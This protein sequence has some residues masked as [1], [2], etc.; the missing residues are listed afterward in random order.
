M[1][2]YQMLY[3]IIQTFRGLCEKTR[4]NKAMKNQSVIVSLCIIDIKSTK[5]NS[6]SF[7]MNLMLGKRMDF[8]QFNFILLSGGDI[9]VGYINS[10]LDQ[11][12]PP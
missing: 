7:I 3:K 10:R 11:E 6:K 1:N 8:N 5:S 9:R 12:D 2:K 4:N